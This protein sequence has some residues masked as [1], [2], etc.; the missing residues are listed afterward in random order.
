M[1]RAPSKR[2]RS[3]PGTEG[4]YFAM[5]TAPNWVSLAAFSML[6]TAD[7]S[8]PLLCMSAAR[9]KQI[10]PRRALQAPCSANSLAQDRG[11]DRALSLNLM[12]SSS[13]F[14]ASAGLWKRAYALPST[15]RARICQKS[16]PFS[17]NLIAKWSVR[18]TH[19]SH[20]A[21]AL[22]YSLW[23]KKPLATCRPCNSSRCALADISARACSDSSPRIICNLR[24]SVTPKRWLRMSSKK[25]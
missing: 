22:W 11:K 24:P 12:P 7:A 13:T 1:A 17:P 21:S 14:M 5:N 19:I 2:F 16:S 6:A 9:S 18:S 15:T 25:D 4:R 3:Y 23:S 8:P 20:S 10:F